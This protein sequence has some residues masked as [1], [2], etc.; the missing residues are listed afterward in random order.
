MSVNGRIADSGK[1][2]SGHPLPERFSS[3]RVRLA[4]S[5]PYDEA[6]LTKANLRMLREADRHMAAF[7][8]VRAKTEA[9]AHVREAER[10]AALAAAREARRLLESVERDLAARAGARYADRANDETR[11]L[12]EA[13]GELVVRDEVR[14]ASWRR[15]ENGQLALANGLPV[16]DWECARPLRVLTRDGLEVLAQKSPAQLR[17]GDVPITQLGYAAG[18]RFRELWERADPERALRPRSLLDYVQVGGGRGGGEDRRKEIADQVARI[19]RAVRA[20]AQVSRQDPDLWSRILQE[21]VAK[22]TPIS[23]AVSSARA[24]ARWRAAIDPILDVLADQF[25]MH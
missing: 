22:G 11:A 4:R 10:G 12:E 15:D 3:Q 18:L 24:R 2:A 25:G 6:P 19:V 7:S 21:V 8:V 16:L 23:R 5:E 9:G 17:R 14:L 1:V 20:Q 13:R